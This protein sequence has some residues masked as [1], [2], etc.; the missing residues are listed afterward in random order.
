MTR[1][2]EDTLV[3]QTT[4]EYLETQLGWDSVYA[5]NDET[6]GKDGTLGRESQQEVVLTRYLRAALEKFNPNLP[7]AAYQDAIRQITEISA[8]QTMFATNREK[9]AMLKDGVQ[10]TFRDDKGELKKERLRVFDFTNAKENHFLCVREL[11]VRGALYRRRADIVG[12]VNGLPLLF[13]ELKNVHHDI[14]A[15][16]EQNFADYKDTVPHLFHHNAIVVLGNGIEAKLGSLSSKFEHFHEWKRLEEEDP[17]TVDMETLLKGVCDKTN[18]MDIFENFIVFDDSSGAPRKVLARNHQFMGVNRAMQSV[19]DRKTRAGKLGVF[20]HTQGSGKSYSMVFF[21]RKVHR[22]LGGNFTFLICTDRDDLDTQ[23]YKTFAGCGLA[24]NDKDRCRASSAKDLAGLLAQHKSYVFS[25][26][27]KFNQKIEQPADA[28]SQREDL[29]V[30]TDEAHRTQYGLLS[31]NMRNALPNASYMGFT[32]TPL[33]KD[34]EITK[35]I[36][37]EYVSTYD[38]QRAVEDKATVPLY[39]DARGDKLGIET[40]D[41]NERIAQK[42]EE[43]DAEIEDDK[44]RQRLER[45]IKSATSHSNRPANDSTRSRAISSSITPPPGKAAKP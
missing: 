36:F 13:M 42:L 1:Y 15:A 28:Y 27:Q 40:N 7:E 4:A 32:G 29:I 44:Y 18:F 19:R 9:Y 23:I 26:I 12:F 38:F 6:F 17:G 41:L 5:Y 31:L 21:T 2:S 14:R 16:Y 20:W 33:F 24:D 30:I 34:D 10:V 37:G 45:E 35:K 22:K 39:Y 11:W 43:L 8:A 3:Q 25:L